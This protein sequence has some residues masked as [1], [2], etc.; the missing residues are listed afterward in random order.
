MLGRL[1]LRNWLSTAS[2]TSSKAQ[3]STSSLAAAHGAFFC[4]RRK[5][6][7]QRPKAAVARNKADLEKCEKQTD[8]LLDMRL[9]E[10]IN[11]QDYVSK[12]HGVVNRKAELKGKMDGFAR[13]SANRFEPAIQFVLAVKHTVFL[14]A[15]GKLIK[16]GSN[17]HMAEKSL[18]VVFK[19][20]WFYLTEFNS[21]P[22]TIL[23]RQ[24]G[25]PLESNWRREGDSNPTKFRQ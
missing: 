21:D 18:T 3:R 10:Q 4:A 19:N 14:L 20:P 24:R 12:K 11:E 15:E 9:N 23:A 16:N 1:H 2:M 5:M 25:N 17:F 22:T 13:N 8:R 7:A 6:A